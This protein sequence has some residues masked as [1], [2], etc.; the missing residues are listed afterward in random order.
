MTIDSFTTVNLAILVL[1][2]GKWITQRIKILRDFNIPDPVVSGLLVSLAIWV[3]QAT[4]GREISFDMT[5]R[6]FLLLAFFACVGL[7]SDLRTLLTGGIPLLVLAGIC[8][9]FTYLQN[10]AAA[11]T[12]AVV[13]IG[14]MAG[15]LGGSVSL[16][17]GHGTVIAMAPEFAEKH[18]VSGAVEIGLACAT[19]GLVASAL[20]G[21]PLAGFL[22]N[23]H[24][25]KPKTKEQPDIGASLGKPREEMGY[26]SLLRVLF[27][28]NI[29]MMIGTL[30]YE[31]LQVAG[32]D[33]PEF[34]CTMFG[35]ILVTNVL[36]V[37]GS[38]QSVVGTRPLALLSD[39]S[40][41]VFLSMSLMSLQLWTIVAL[42]GPIVVLVVIQT[43]IAV[44][45]AMLIL[46]PLLGRDY[47]AAVTCAG[48][49]GFTLGATPTAMANMAAVTQ[50][51][52]N[53]HRAFVLVPLVG[54]FFLSVA[55]A[56]IVIQFLGWFGK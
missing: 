1:G 35:G 4:T 3:L 26:F 44:I 9:G 13:G 31:K 27:L 19:L 8:L 41:G 14:S 52:G 32:I 33:M 37:F 42:A 23:R 10:F 30:L 5:A 22:I 40:L 56:L 38:K 28:M 25:L 55:N 24:K 43:A 29:S 36:P 6:D 18:G 39:I 51:Y 34:V 11:L 7:G 46:F 45:F 20:V 16:V 49:C 53:A 48:F 2:I 12:G 47:E 21:G 54:G 50:Q 15:L 17:G